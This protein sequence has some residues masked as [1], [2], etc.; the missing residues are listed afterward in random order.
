[1]FPVLKKPPG[2]SGYKV[3]TANTLT[4]ISTQDGIIKLVS[5]LV[6]LWLL[7]VLI[8]AFEITFFSSSFF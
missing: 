2:V 1:M 8:K 5:S 4:N 6:S 3:I 7:T